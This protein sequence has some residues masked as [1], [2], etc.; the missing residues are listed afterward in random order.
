MARPPK[1]ERPPINANAIRIDFIPPS[2]EFAAEN[3]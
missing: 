3:T 2:K 1:A